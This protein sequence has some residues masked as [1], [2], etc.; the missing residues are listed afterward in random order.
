MLADLLVQLCQLAVCHR[1]T[2]LLLCRLLVVLAAQP[3]LSHLLHPHHVNIS[4]TDRIVFSTRADTLT[5]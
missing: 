2:E 4:M 5:S 1:P 3:S